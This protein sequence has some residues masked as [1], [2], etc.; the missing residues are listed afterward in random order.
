M[1]VTTEDPI[2]THRARID[3]LD[4]EILRLLAER[5]DVSRQ[6]QQTRLAGGGPR[7]QHSRE[8]QIIGRYA[9]AFGRPGTSLAMTVLE[10]CRGQ[11]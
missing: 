1:T 9:D 5:R 4:A 3:E 7:I 8:M 11:R 6:I 2:A 10:I